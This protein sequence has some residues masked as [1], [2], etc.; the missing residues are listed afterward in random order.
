M[1]PKDK[2]IAY[3][4]IAQQE[5]WHIAISHFLIDKV[6]IFLWFTIDQNNI[7]QVKP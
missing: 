3:I 7:R 6:N 5:W 2:H 4:G 1:G